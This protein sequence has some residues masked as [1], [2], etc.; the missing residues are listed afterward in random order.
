M[1]RFAAYRYSVLIALLL[2]GTGG[3]ALYRRAT[4]PPAYVRN[5]L[6]EPMPDVVVER[7]SG[8]DVRLLQFLGGRAALVYVFS[9]AQCASCSNLG[10][11]FRILKTAYPTLRTVLVGSGSSVSE[12]RTAFDAQGVSEQDAVVDPS[13]A[14]LHGLSLTHEPIVLLADSTGRIVFVDPR[15]PSQAAQYPMGRVLTDLQG[16]LGARP[17]GVTK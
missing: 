17:A 13:R 12:F 2:A 15:T 4:E 9:A 1:S 3:W 11:E 6:G 7:T 10:L 14:L 8:A 5:P 16:A